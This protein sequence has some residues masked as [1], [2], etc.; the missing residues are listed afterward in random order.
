MVFGLGAMVMTVAGAVPA[1]AD[2]IACDGEMFGVANMLPA[3]V[4][5]FEYAGVRDADPSSFDVRET[6]TGTSVPFRLE[7]TEEGFRLRLE[8]VLVP[9]VEY[10]VLWPMRC[11]HQ[12]FVETDT[13]TAMEPAPIPTTLGTLSAGPL[14][15]TNFGNEGPEYRSYFIEL[16]LD[17]SEDVFP[18]WGSFE[19]ASFVD[20][21]SQVEGHPI[22]PPRVSVDCDN[23][24]GRIGEGT[25]TIWLTGGPL[26]GFAWVESNRIEIEVDCDE[27]VY[28]DSG[29]LEPVPWPDDSEPD[30][31][32]PVVVHSSS[33]DGGC[34]TQDGAPPTTLLSLFFVCLGLRRTQR[35][36]V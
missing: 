6:E 9:D 30:P 1:Q 36:E 5:G 11:E 33:M 17:P 15:A 3:N 4:A 12:E 13:F 10:E 14:M 7:S 32:E 28:V 26:V 23:S 2:S 8:E 35:S 20:G 21:E 22:N 16:Q 29:T 24:G 25:F 27:A 31:V 18:W 19:H 34:S